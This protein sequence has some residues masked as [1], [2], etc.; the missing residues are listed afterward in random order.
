MSATAFASPEIRAAFKLRLGQL[1]GL[2]LAVAALL[3]VLALVSY[4]PHDPSINTAT[5]RH[6]ANWVG[7][8]GA[9]TADLLLQSFG[10]AAALP[11]VALLAW[12]WRLLHDPRLHAVLRI[13]STLLALPVVAAL[14]ASAPQGAAPW[15]TS[16]GLGGAIGGILAHGLLGMGEGMLRARRGAADPLHPRL[17]R[18]RARVACAGLDRAGVAGR[19]KRRGRSGARVLARWPG[20]GRVSGAHQP[21][22]QPSPARL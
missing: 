8:A 15:P 2:A 5:S 11:V 21:A 18:P 1:A 22:L 10:L 12:A 4:N 9:T 6:P 19:R 16:A 20:R 13:L 17:A 7:L 14:L 3:L